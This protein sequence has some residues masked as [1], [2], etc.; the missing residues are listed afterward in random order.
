[1]T[2]QCRASERTQMDTLLRLF[3][4]P[5]AQTGLY[6]YFTPGELE[7]DEQEIEA[8]VKSCAERG[9]LGIIPRLS[10]A[11]VAITG[12][13]IGTGA[14]LCFGER[15]MP[16][17]PSAAENEKRADEDERILLLWRRMYAIL[18]RKAKAHGLKLA[19]HVE[20]LLE[21]MAVRG[22]CG[23]E[24][25]A[26]ML[27]RRE[28]YLDQGQN[29]TLQLS[30]KGARQAVVAVDL[31]DAQMVD[32]RTMTDETGC[33]RWDVPSGNWC[34]H[35][36]LCVPDLEPRVDYMSYEASRAA[37]DAVWEMFSDIF[38][39]YTE[40]LAVLHMAN[41]GF[42]APNR[43][44]WT[45][46]FN[47]RYAAMFG[48][49][50]APLYP[51]LYEIEDADTPVVKA[52]L[53]ACRAE[54]LRQ[55]IYR[56]LADAAGAHG[57]RLICSANE[58]KLSA[59]SV[60]S[61]DVVRNSAIAPCAVLDRAYMYGVNSLKISAA[62]ADNYGE[63]TVFCEMYRDYVRQD[64]DILYRDAIHAFGCGAN[65]LAAHLPLPLLQSGEGTDYAAFVA[66]SSALLCGGDHQSDIALLYPVHSLH[67]AVSFYE[68]AASSFEYPDPPVDTDY[69]VLL[70]TVAAYAGRDVTLLHPDVMS[71]RCV[72]KDGALVLCREDGAQMRFG[73][74]VLPAARML[75]PKVAKLVK[76]F[77]ESGGKIIATGESLPTRA[78]ST[79]GES[80]DRYVR[81]C[82]R[83]VF[84]EAALD[85]DIV[86]GRLHTQNERGG[87]AYWLYPGQTGA[88]GCMMVDGAAVAR[89]LWGFALPFDVIIPAMPRFADTGALSNPY[90]EFATLG[91]HRG[92][93]GGG[94]FRYL[95][96]VRQGCDIYFF[97]NATDVDFSD[98]VL[99]RGVHKRLTLCDP[100]TGAVTPLPRETVCH[101]GEE[102]TKIRLCVPGVRARFVLA[103]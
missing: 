98:E 34:I 28:Y 101:H 74:L 8:F 18:L 89:A 47:A 82:M 86:V 39:Q 46:Q 54:L 68:K 35:E 17:L 49:D 92:I 83:T 100:H 44:N 79:D 65:R 52:H 22:E 26:R 84:G 11:A 2:D 75:H 102:Y 48:T 72:V 12:E 63:E 96:K 55:G 3:E 43:R 71:E 25:R 42:H 93:P 13:M 53:F 76:E 57:L 37:L 51:H 27:T 58:P 87:E 15:E 7:L 66:R 24:M 20:P 40:T 4:A 10:P 91:L 50:P 70:N 36:F 60:I 16:T 21:R 23:R 32:L 45:P 95:H 9:V 90:P 97:G 99:L 38:A 78:F 81:E 19:F 56:A 88:D 30:S 6:V 59:P 94:M 41:V 64:A 33:L 29:V 80:A 1:M 67:S 103:E 61:G 62:G 14:P 31:M 5:P 85:P 77:Y 73:V 69:T